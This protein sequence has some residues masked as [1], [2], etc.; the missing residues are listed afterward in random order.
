MV[1]SMTCKLLLCFGLLLFVGGI[2]TA[3]N[4]TFDFKHATLSSNFVAVATDPTDSGFVAAGTIPVFTLGLQGLVFKFNKS[5]Q[6]VW[7]NVFGG[8]Q[9]EIIK[10]VDATLDHGAV[11]VGWMLHPHDEVTYDI[12]L[13]KYDATGTQEWLRYLSPSLD[14][15]NY[16]ADVQQT[17]DGG[18]VIAGYIYCSDFTVTPN[19]T[20]QDYCV[21][22][23]DADG[24]VQWTQIW[25]ESDYDLLDCIRERSDGG[26]VV[27]GLD[28]DDDGV[29]NG[30]Y[31]AGLN[32][33]GGI[34]WEYSGPKGSSNSAKG[35]RELPSGGFIIS[36]K[37]DGSGNSDDQ[38][39]RLD[40]AGDHMWTHTYPLSGT[41]QPSDVEVLCDGGF[42][43]VT[44][45]YS[46]PAKGADCSVLRVAPDG[47]EIARHSYGLNNGDF[48]NAA[49]YTPDGGIVIAAM[50]DYVFSPPNTPFYGWVFKITDGARRLVMV[51]GDNLPLSSKAVEFRRLLSENPNWRDT[52]AYIDTTDG[53]GRICACDTL[54]GPDAPFKIRKLLHSEP[55]IRHGAEL[56][57]KYSVTVDNMKI[58]EFGAVRYDTLADLRTQD[59]VLDH[60]TIGINLVTSIQW[61]TRD[62]YLNSLQSGFRTMANYLY[63]VYNGQVTI[64]TVVI[65]DDAVLWDDADIQIFA[66][67]M[68]WPRATPTGFDDPNFASVKLPRQFYG[69]PDDTRNKTFS[70]YP[71]VLT[72]P[73]HFRTLGHEL[74]H[75]LFGF[76]DEYEF[77]GADQRCP[78]ISNYGHMDSHYERAEP[79]ASE[80]SSSLQYFDPA[81]QNNVQYTG[82][83]MSCFDLFESMF[84]KAW[85]DDSVFAAIIKPTE[86][87]LPG[88]D[89][90]AEGPNGYLP[91]PDYN[92]GALVIFP[93]P[94]FDAASVNKVVTSFYRNT[95]TVLRKVNVELHK[96]SGLR[97][98]QGQTSDTGKI[99]VLDVSPGD[100][101]R[102]GGPARLSV[103]SSRAVEEDWLFAEALTTGEGKS[104]LGNYYTALAEDSIDMEL[105][106]VYGDHN[107]IVDLA[108]SAHGSE[109]RLYVSGPFSEPPSL[110][111]SPDAGVGGVSP[112]LLQGSTY[113]TDISGELANGGIMTLSALDDSGV[114][115]VVATDYAAADPSDLGQFFAA[116]GSAIFSPDA[117]IP[118]LEKLALVTSAYPILR[119][120]LTD[121]N[122]QA[123]KTAALALYPLLS[124][125]GTSRIT[126]RYQDSDLE[127]PAGVRG[128]E[129]SLR[130]FRWNEEET[131]WN[132]VGGQPD[133]VFNEVTADINAAGV[134]GAFTTT[135]AS[136]TPCGDVDASGQ[137]DI[138][139]AVYLI[140]YIFASGQPPQD[141]AAGDI[142]CNGQT[143]ITD[144]VFMINYI[145]ASGAVPC[146]GCPQ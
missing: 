78:S 131:T 44:T 80:L 145:F 68:E 53:Q 113:T 64:D 21:I 89:Q 116:D 12:F 15:D 5:G 135:A 22:K 134:Y 23:T 141:S 111:H 59:I 6:T 36:A 105:S 139:D 82:T 57:T 75:Y 13:A 58:D 143:D 144:A 112:F 20:N 38:L 129:L 51:D 30:V 87:T 2:S 117:A 146:A 124:L 102:A 66:S 54:F 60:T 40:G 81:C 101:I 27:A 72:N 109:C 107:F 41:Q 16:S 83:G 97:I 65:F 11:V 26:F 103:A 45:D 42:A 25:S 84:E 69:S 1:L 100:K 108:L 121:E 120:G 140:N 37:V 130:I 118:A 126:I 136:A 7:A 91:S 39:V 104:G 62:G 85:G 35:V 123:G 63:D 119:N 93:E 8:G 14:C 99:R 137:I 128:D 28:S 43:L 106:P 98:P 67:N 114:T 55:S 17:L 74:G 125:S 48:A 86:R 47:T 132:Q 19:I 122:I 127:L 133:T 52:L 95:S 18:F 79:M 71:Y 96:A 34:E 50:R 3:Q 9:N 33:G 77:V 61:N 56:H 24:E 49:A 138:T 88:S 76:H 90:Y 46:V 94:D 73:L 92:V 32:S 4:V 10:G 70:I 142:D 115:F 29:D 31:V 110:E